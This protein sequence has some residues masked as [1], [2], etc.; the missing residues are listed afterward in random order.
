MEVVFDYVATARGDTVSFSHI[1]MK[2]DL[3]ESLMES[4]FERYYWILTES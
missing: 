1:V 2:Q 3:S 4:Q